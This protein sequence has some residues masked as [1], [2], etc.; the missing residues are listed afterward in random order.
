[1]SPGEDPLLAFCRSLPAA[2]EDVKWEKNLVFSVGGKMFAAFN[3]PEGEPFGFKTDPETFALLVRH[4]GI[5]PAKY[6]ARAHWVSIQG[7]DV[8]PVGAVQ[9]LLEEA[10]AIVARKLPKKLQ[11]SLGLEAG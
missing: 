5:E 4:D 9:D 7:R 2:T 1:M 11:R 8:M 10:H 6:L 3:L